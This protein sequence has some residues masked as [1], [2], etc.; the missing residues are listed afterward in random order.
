VTKNAKIHKQEKNGYEDK[1]VEEKFPE[2]LEDGI[3]GF[4]FAHC[5]LVGVGGFV[6]QQVFIKFFV[7][8]QGREIF[9]A[10]E[11]VL[12]SSALFEICF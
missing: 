11:E 10:D 9:L 12:E 8:H 7:C 4:R 2:F 5:G 1:E 3:V 6:K